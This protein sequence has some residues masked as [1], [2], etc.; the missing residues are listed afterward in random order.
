MESRCIR[1]YDSPIEGTGLVATELIP[2]G[3]VIWKASPDDIKL[4]ARELRRLPR[5][6]HHLVYQCGDR[7]ILTVDGSQYMN[8]SCDPNTWWLGDE[9]TVARRDIQPGEEITY[10]YASSD[11]HPWRRP[12]DAGCLSTPTFE[13]VAN[14]HHVV[15]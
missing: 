5:E 15:R 8:H 2:A 3:T 1:T 13:L 7:F 6:Q 14:G 9:T 4:T 12:G 10:D 11:V